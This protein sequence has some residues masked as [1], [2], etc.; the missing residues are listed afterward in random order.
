MC[1]SFFDES[2]IVSCNEP[3]LRL[4]FIDDHGVFIGV[5]DL[6]KL[7]VD[8]GTLVGSIT[9][10]LNTNDVGVFGADRYECDNADL[11]PDCG[12]PDT[13]ALELAGVPDDGGVSR[14]LHL[15][16]IRSCQIKKPTNDS[17]EMLSDVPVDM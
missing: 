8:A 16:A 15:L 10:F 13:E 6:V 1:P 2:R 7:E 14:Y 17:D 12:G 9:D 11:R 3:Y 4:F 5:M